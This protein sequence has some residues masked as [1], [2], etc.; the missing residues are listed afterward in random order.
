MHDLFLLTPKTLKGRHSHVMD[1]ETEHQRG[2]YLSRV[3]QVVGGRA[4]TCSLDSLILKSPNFQLEFAVILINN[5]NGILLNIRFSLWESIRVLRKPFIFHALDSDE[6]ISSETLN[7]RA[8][9][10]WISPSILLTPKVSEPSSK[11]TGRVRR[12]LVLIHQGLGQFCLERR[13]MT[14]YL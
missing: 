10:L 1:E 12:V 11:E 8:D 14:P 9:G 3:T 6:W 4:E 13:K 7:H 5:L 2:S